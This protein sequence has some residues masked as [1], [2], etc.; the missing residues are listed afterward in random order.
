MGCGRLTGADIF[1]YGSLL[2]VLGFGHAIHLLDAATG[3]LQSD[4]DTSYC[5]KQLFYISISQFH[6]PIMPNL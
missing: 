5:H 1:G 3:K 2:L 4:N 6:K